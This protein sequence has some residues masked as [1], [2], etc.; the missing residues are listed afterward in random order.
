MSNLTSSIRFDGSLY[1]DLTEFPINL[2]PT[3]DAH[4]LLSSFSPAYNNNQKVPMEKLQI[5]ELTNQAF[6]EDNLFAKINTEKMKFMACSLLYRGDAP[7]KDIC[8]ALAEIKANN[9]VLFEE[10]AT[11]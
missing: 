1:N 6:N 11:N 2:C 3:T 5:G 10:W 9:F 7:Q 4:F 8:A